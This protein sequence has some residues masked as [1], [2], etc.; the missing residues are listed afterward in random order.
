[1]PV[2]PSGLNL[3]LGMKIYTDECH[4]NEVV[5]SI[6]FKTPVSLLRLISFTTL[7]HTDTASPD[8]IRKAG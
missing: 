3:C 4:D 6:L 1:M 7:Y 2:I 5:G 8:T